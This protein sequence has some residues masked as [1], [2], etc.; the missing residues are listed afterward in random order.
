M[1][2]R[3]EPARVRTGTL[4]TAFCRNLSVLESQEAAR[5]LR[6]VVVAIRASFEE[7]P[8]TSSEY[9]IARAGSLSAGVTT[10]FSGDSVRRGC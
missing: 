4:V 1:W 9:R 6:G 8:D 2:L 7:S 3:E 5:H 10:S